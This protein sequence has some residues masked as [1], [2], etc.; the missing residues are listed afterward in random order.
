MAKNWTQDCS[1][2]VACN[3]QLILIIFVWILRQALAIYTLNM[4]EIL[5]VN[6][7]YD[8]LE[9]YQDF[10]MVTKTWKTSTI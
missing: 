4:A 10:A 6:E 5:I 9:E 3:D 1:L 7:S 2:S 8:H